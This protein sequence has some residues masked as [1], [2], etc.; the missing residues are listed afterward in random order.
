MPVT[1]SVRPLTAVLP[2]FTV[3]RSTLF[4]RGLPATPL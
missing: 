2:A 4:V 1:M 3:S